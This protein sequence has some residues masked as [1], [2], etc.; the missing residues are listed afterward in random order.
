[1]YDHIV[2]YSRNQHRLILTILQHI[3]IGI[4]TNRE[5]VRR[6]LRTAFSSVCKDNLL[7]VYGES[8]VRIDGHTEKT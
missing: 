7:C 6:H 2:L 8:S 4:I 1:M 3:M 5:D